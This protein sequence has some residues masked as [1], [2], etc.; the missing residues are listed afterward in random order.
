MTPHRRDAVAAAARE[1]RVSRDPAALKIF[2]TDAAPLP[3][4]DHG[5]VVL[6]GTFRQHE[7]A[8]E[9]RDERQ[10][11]GESSHSWCARGGS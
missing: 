5:P 10:E 11:D 9:V 1:F 7:R 2:D 6:P 8:A 4:D 3:G